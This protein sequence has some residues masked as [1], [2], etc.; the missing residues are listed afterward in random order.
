MITI[1]ATITE[2]GAHPESIPNLK[3]GNY[4]DGE[5]YHY[6]ES[7]Q[8]AEAWKAEQENQPQIPIEDEFFKDE[9]IVLLWGKL[10]DK[11]DLL[12]EKTIDALKQ[13]LK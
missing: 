4:F 6:F 2:K 1:P 13:K 8:E 5:N 7:K 12:D 11:I 9:N 10:I 3:F